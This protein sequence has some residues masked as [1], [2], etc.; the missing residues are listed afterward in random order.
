[1]TLGDDEHCL[2][3]KLG[4]AYQAITD[5]QGLHA[6]DLAVNLDMNRG[7]LSDIERGKRGTP[8]Q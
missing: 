3:L 8:G 7:H 4:G 1:M 6:D 5:E 2:L